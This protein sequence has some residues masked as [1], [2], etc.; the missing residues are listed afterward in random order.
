MNQKLSG[1]L[2]A[3]GVALFLYRLGELL[4][5][6]SSWSDFKTPAGTGEIVMLLG[7]V[8]VAIVGA[9]GL[10]LGSLLDAVKA[11]AKKTP[12]ILLAAA[13]SGAA[14]SSGCGGVT[15]APSTKPVIQKTDLEKIAE[16]VANVGILVR[17]LQQGEIA[18]FEAGKISPAAH[19]TFQSNL[20][21]FADATLLAL[22]AAKD[23]SKTDATRRDLVDQALKLG[24]RLLETGIIPI[25]DPDAKANLR[26]TLAGIRALLAIVPI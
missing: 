3:G 10:D 11:G 15:P 8:I 24:D 23:L 16:R 4:Q 17:G 20:K 18:F 13:L 9:L 25:E 26:A 6:H 12:A 22:E 1:A 5:S 21:T 19:R 2:L 14:L 7:G